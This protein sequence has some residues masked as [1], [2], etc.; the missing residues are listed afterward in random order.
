M[1]AQSNVIYPRY[2]RQGPSASTRSGE[3]LVVL[4]VLPFAPKAVA[5]LRPFGGRPTGTEIVQT[6]NPLGSGAKTKP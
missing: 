3:S 4:W 2:D 1:D 5:S 6:E